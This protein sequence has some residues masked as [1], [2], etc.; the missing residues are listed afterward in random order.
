MITKIII[1]INSKIKKYSVPVTI[2]QNKNQTFI[3][4]DKNRC[5]SVKVRKK[6]AEAKSTIVA[7]VAVFQ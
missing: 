6:S 1:I 4:Q 2:I 3:C 5:L 7:P